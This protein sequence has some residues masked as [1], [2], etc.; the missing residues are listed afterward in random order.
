[1]LHLS[2]ELA[3]QPRCENAG[4]LIELL[5]REEGKYGMISV[6]GEF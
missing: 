5:G 3:S 4:S 2:Q 6:V 1:M